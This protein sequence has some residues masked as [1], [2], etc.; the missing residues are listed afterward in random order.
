M[1]RRPNNDYNLEE[2]Q[3]GTGRLYLNKLTNIKTEAFVPTLEPDGPAMH[4]DASSLSELPEPSA[5]CRTTGPVRRK[6]R[7][8]AVVK[9][10][11]FD[12]F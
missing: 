4:P 11:H 2:R 7:T 10:D 6:Q 3:D 1:I 8:G 12:I 5:V 9:R